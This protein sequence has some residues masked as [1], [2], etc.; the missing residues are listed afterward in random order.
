MGRRYVTPATLTILRSDPPREMQLFLVGYIII[1][2]CEI[3]TVG[4]FPL[5][6]KV[7][8]VWDA[9]T[10]TLQVSDKI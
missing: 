3:F 4:G 2:I 10:I 1:E 8:L 7:R 5:D 9:Y 6:K